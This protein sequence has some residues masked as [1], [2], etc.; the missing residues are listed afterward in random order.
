[1]QRNKVVMLVG[2]E[3]T[4]DLLACWLTQSGG[5][6]TLVDDADDVGAKIAET[7]A[8]AVLT[9]RLYGIGIPS[10][11]ISDIKAR[12]P[13]L[14]LAVVPVRGY[15]DGDMERLARVVGADMVV[16]TA[17]GRAELARLIRPEG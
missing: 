7:D 9:D 3:P 1:M 16:S 8:G 2:D 14:R 13:G 5:D 6:V 15:L 10:A 4:R 17:A 11:T 12:F